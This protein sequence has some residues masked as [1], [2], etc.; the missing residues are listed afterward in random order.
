MFIGLF[1]KF[2]CVLFFLESLSAPVS[3]GNVHGID[4]ITG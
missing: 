4:S 1:Y 3:T 2:D